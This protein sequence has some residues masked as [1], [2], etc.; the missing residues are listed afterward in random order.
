MPYQQ[1][2]A[3]KI[4]IAQELPKQSTKIQQITATQD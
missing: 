2:G 4:Y 3:S 1:K